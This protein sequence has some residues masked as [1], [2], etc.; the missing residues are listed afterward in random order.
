MSPLELAPN[1]NLE[2]TSR[3]LVADCTGHVSVPI[4]EIETVYATLGYTPASVG[5]HSAVN[6]SII[7]TS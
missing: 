5:T 2:E 4:G 3:R 6:S 7:S 1:G